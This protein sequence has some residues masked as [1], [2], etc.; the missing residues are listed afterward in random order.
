MHNFEWLNAIPESDWSPVDDRVRVRNFGV[1]EFAINS[2]IDQIDHAQFNQW[3]ASQQRRYRLADTSV[4]VGDP[5]PKV[6]VIWP[7]Y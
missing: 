3:G 7:N 5:E 6:M 2:G 1:E 4:I